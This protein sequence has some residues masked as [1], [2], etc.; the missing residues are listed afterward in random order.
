MKINYVVNNDNAIEAIESISNLKRATFVGV[1]SE[2]TGLSCHSH[3][4]RLLQFGV[5][6]T[7]FVFDL[8]KIGV[9]KFKTIFN[10][11]I[12]KLKHLVL[13]L[14]NGKFDIQF[15]WSIGIDIGILNLFDTMLAGNVLEA[16]LAN[17][18]G[19]QY[20]VERYLNED[21]SKD[22]QVSDWSA[23]VLSKA[24]IEYAA[25]DAIQTARLAKVLIRHLKREN[26][27]NVFKLEMRT[28]RATASMEYWGIRLNTDTLDNLKPIYE[29]KAKDYQLEFLSH[30][31]DRV[32]IYDLFDDPITYGLD[33][34]SSQQVLAGLVKIGIPDP[35]DS[36][37]PLQSTAS[38]HL[39]LLDLVDYPALYPLLNFR[40]INKLLTSYVYNLPS[41]VNPDSG[42]V[43]G[44]FNQCVR[45]GRYS[46]S[47]PN[48]QNMP[49]ADG[50][51]ENIRAAF[52]PQD[53]Y[54][55]VGCDYSQIELRVMAEVSGD[56]AMLQE[57]LDGK[58]PYST[59]AARMMNLSYEDFMALD[60]AVYKANRQ[61][62]KAVKLG[63]QYGMW[64]KKLKNY[65]KQTYGVTMSEKEAKKYYDGFFEMY[66]GLKDY[67][68]QFSSKSCLEAFS[69]PP[70]NRRRIWEE[71]P[72]V[73]QLCNHPVQ[74]TSA[75]I[76]KLALS[77][78]YDD[79]YNLGYHP[80]LSDKMKLLITVHDEIVMETETDKQ[81]E[82]IELL[83]KD[84]L[85]AASTVLKICPVEAEAHAM[86][87]LAEK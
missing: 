62:A 48:L 30:I 11:Y 6:D 26:L 12:P 23:E 50:Q 37:L 34:T 79:L 25:I 19:L 51:P 45:T 61:S 87:S 20:M 4:I 66:P 85:G 10:S 71:Y 64:W 17:R 49:R 67:H 31:P 41:L 82:G 53:G 29:N 38:T 33:I 59:V 56:A 18:F 63:L 55:F 46:S 42:R 44:S 83:Q 84:M 80:T 60:S 32:E 36:K 57:F 13:C 52:I 5:E 2:T 24:Q 8:F 54:V 78:L 3:K 58:D 74:G 72:G 75:D 39:K 47:N 9:E 35:L 16:G 14:H 77:E 7:C 70:F 1:D 40:K 81:E 28:L 22:E 65:A 27:I 73:P 15:L 86:N 43:H 21:M 68:E 69:L 76:T